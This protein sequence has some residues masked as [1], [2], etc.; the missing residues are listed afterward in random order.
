MVKCISVYKSI[1]HA[2]VSTMVDDGAKNANDY[3][4]VSTMVADDVPTNAEYV[5]PLASLVWLVAYARVAAWLTT[6]KDSSREA[7]DN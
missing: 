6:P 7:R 3:A 1:S 2:I 5:A 4:D